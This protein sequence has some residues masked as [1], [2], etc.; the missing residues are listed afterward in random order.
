MKYLATALLLL[1]FALPVAAQTST[2]LF[3]TRAVWFATVLRDGGWPV[4]GTSASSQEQALRQRIRQA[5]QSFLAHASALGYPRRKR[6]TPGAYAGYLEENDIASHTDLQTL[7]GAYVAA[8]YSITEPSSAD[9][10]AAESAWSSI[11][12]SSP[13]ETA[14]QP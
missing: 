10:D 6:Q 2:P 7:T 4:Q 14:P 5:Y 1:L 9:V 3:E 12:H 8:R 13:D 11:Q